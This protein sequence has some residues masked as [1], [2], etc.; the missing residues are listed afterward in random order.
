MARSTGRRPADPEARV[1]DA[2]LSAG[3]GRPPRT[4]DALTD[5]IRL[6]ARSRAPQL[7]LRLV[8]SLALTIAGRARRLGL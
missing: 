1:L 5:L 2:D 8:L 7:R 4:L 6:V 3:T